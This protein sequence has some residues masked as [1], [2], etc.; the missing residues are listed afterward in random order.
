[1]ALEDILEGP[2]RMHRDM[3]H[4]SPSSARCASSTPTPGPQTDA[5][6]VPGTRGA[7]S[8]RAGART[9][10]RRKGAGRQG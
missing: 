10:A 8:R 6:R 7:R 9:V 5:R 3:L 4:G 2:E 1:M